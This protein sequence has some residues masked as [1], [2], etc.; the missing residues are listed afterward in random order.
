MADLVL[1]N[2]LT[3]ANASATTGLNSQ[4]K[5]AVMTYDLVKQLAAKSGVE[6]DESAIARAVVASMAAPIKAAV[7]AA[8]AAG[9][10]A[11]AIADAVVARLASALVT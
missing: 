1:T 7:A 10:S 11:D 4:W 3:K 9:G 6:V 8:V 2:P 5:Y